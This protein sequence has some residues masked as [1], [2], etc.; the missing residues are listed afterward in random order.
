MQARKAT[1]YLSPEESGNAWRFAKVSKSISSPTVQFTEL[2]APFKCKWT[3]RVGSPP[4]GPPPQMGTT[5]EMNDALLILPDEDRTAKPTAIEFA[6]SIARSVLNS[7]GG[8][9]V[10]SGLTCSCGT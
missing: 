3:P 6:G 9:L 7:N 4:L 10:T 8:V 5:K 1:T 2:I